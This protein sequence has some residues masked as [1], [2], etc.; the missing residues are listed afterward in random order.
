[1]RTLKD[2]LTRLLEMAVIAIMAALVLVVLWG[3]VS[4]FV[5]AEPS[6]WTEELATSPWLHCSWPALSLDCW[7]V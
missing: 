4:R 7:L 3:V 1:M 6:R 2:S 5:L